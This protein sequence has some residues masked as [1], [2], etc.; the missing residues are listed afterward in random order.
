MN[1]R[2][3]IATLALSACL[4]TSAWASRPP[5]LAKAYQCID[6]TARRDTERGA[7]QRSFGDTT[8]QFWAGDARETQL[9]SLVHQLVDARKRYR[10]GEDASAITELACDQVLELEKQILETYRGRQKTCYVLPHYDDS[11]A[12]EPGASTPSRRDPNAPSRGG[13]FA[14]GR[15]GVTYTQNGDGTVTG[16]DGSTY[17]TNG[18]STTRSDGVTFTRNGSQTVDSNGVT[19]TTTGNVTTGS[20]GTVCVQV[21][22]SVTCN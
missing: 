10:S 3:R 21:G 14:G 16:S 4:S 5:E 15:P 18:G 13:G 19:Y 2:C 20:N 17:T 11:D 12:G 8:C 9:N 7:I 6:E 1:T 22:P